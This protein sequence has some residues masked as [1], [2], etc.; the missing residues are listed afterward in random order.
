MRWRLTTPNHR[1][2]RQYPNRAI[3]LPLRADP[4][5]LRQTKG[6]R[7]FMEQIWHDTIDGSRQL[8]RT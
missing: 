2:P 7:F 5:V 8:V 6:C 1:T 3:G 4:T